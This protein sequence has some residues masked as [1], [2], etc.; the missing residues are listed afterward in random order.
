MV[1]EYSMRSGGRAGKSSSCLLI[2]KVRLGRS[3]VAFF[4]VSLFEEEAS[5]KTIGVS[6]TAKHKVRMAIMAEE[7]FIL[8]ERRTVKKSALSSL[9]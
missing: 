7:F 9:S 6:S 4:A 2:D 3:V 5:V 1:Q 8:T